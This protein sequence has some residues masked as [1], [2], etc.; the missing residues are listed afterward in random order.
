MAVAAEVEHG[1]AYF[2]AVSVSEIA[3]ARRIQETAE[4]KTEGV[5][6]GFCLIRILGMDLQNIR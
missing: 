3:V 1:A 5:F 4:R 2:V 6:F